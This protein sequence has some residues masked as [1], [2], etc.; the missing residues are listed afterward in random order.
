MFEVVNIFHNIK[1]KVFESFEDLHI[2]SIIVYLYFT[3][4]GSDCQ[5]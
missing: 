4:T 1:E 5:H 2:E 3:I